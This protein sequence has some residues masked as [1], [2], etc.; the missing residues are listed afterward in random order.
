M[1]WGEKE[2]VNTYYLSIFFAMIVLVTNRVLTFLMLQFAKLI[3]AQTLLIS[4]Q[5]G[6]VVTFLI[7]PVRLELFW[8]WCKRC[9]K[10]VE[11]AT[12]SGLR[13]DDF[14]DW[15]TVKRLLPFLLPCE[16]LHEPVEVLLG[17]WQRAAVLPV[18]V[19]VDAFLLAVLVG[20]SFYL[21]IDVAKI[22]A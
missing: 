13:Y 21:S 19:T 16:L 18:V 3:A 17:F 9:L 22:E 6:Q 11:L 10:N 1:L 2:M 4:F 20:I 14:G 7:K 5:I 8:L 12:D 15:H